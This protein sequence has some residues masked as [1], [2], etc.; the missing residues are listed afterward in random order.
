M[1]GNQQSRLLFFDFLRIICIGLIVIYHIAIVLPIYEIATAPLEFNLFYLNIGIL[2]VSV[3]ILVSGAVIELTYTHMKTIHDYVEYIGKR[4]QRIY[5]AFWLSLLIGL[6][7]NQQLLAT[8]LNRLLWEFSGFN[9][10][11]GDWGGEINVSTWFIGLIV[12]LYLIYP[13]LSWMLKKYPMTTL[14]CTFL[15]TYGLRYF[16]N[17]YHI[18]DASLPR[19]LPLCNLF[20]FTLG[21][22]IVQKRFYPQTVY[23]SKILLF[24]SELSFYVFLTH[25]TFLHIAKINLPFYIMMVFIVAV[26]AYLFDKSLQK[27]FVKIDKYATILINSRIDRSLKQ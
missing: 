15:I 12:V 4:V 2:S 24:L 3:F 1:S 5:P 25:V 9:A 13:Y 23:N 27:Q 21:I 16:L 10:F 26:M 11:T 8:P 7:I 18:G 20:M 17:Y 6:M 14:I 19:W 22:F